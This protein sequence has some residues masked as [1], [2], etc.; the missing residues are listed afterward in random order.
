MDLRNVRTFI[1]LPYICMLPLIF[2]TISYAQTERWVY[3]Y[4]GTGYWD[5]VARDIVYGLDGNIY[6]AGSSRSNFNLDDFTVISLSSSGSERWVYTN[7]WSGS[8]DHAYGVTYGLDG[9]IYV[10]GGGDSSN[11]WRGTVISLTPP[12]SERWI[13][14]GNC[15]ALSG[16]SITYGSD[17]YIYGVAASQG[18]WSLTSS[19]AERWF[20]VDDSLVP[21]GDI[22]YGSD[23]HIYVPGVVYRSDPRWD[24]AVLS[25]TS[26]GIKRWLY[27]YNSI[28]GLSANAISI[29]CG[30]DGNIYAVGYYYTDPITY[31]IMVASIT[32]SGNE[33]WIYGT[34]TNYYTSPY[35]DIVYGSD[36]NLY[37]TVQLEDSVTHLAVISL[38]SSGSERWIYKD[39]TGMAGS[40][41]SIVY[42][43]DDY[44]Y[45]TGIIHRL[46][47]GNDFAIV[48]LTSS[49]SEIWIYTHNGSWGV[50]DQPT[51]MVYGTDGNIYAAGISDVGGAVFEDFAVISVNPVTGIEKHQS[52]YG[53]STNLLIIPNPF[54]SKT[55]IK[56]QTVDDCATTIKICD[57]SGRVVKHFENR[58][59]LNYITWNGHDDYDNTLP[60]GVYFLQFKAGD[61]ST[62]EKLL[63]LR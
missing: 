30:T 7:D 13:Y 62:T 21:S 45:A 20:Y 15:G 51:S 25:L 46:I 59:N 22:V 2:T 39:T 12:G 19:G 35:Y 43:S 57:V 6:A 63:L 52:T 48:G 11:I 14:R 40:G 8:W 47:T 34:G 29:C 49:G 4:N 17:G 54:Y 33:R 5:D 9:N 24:F 18:V 38:T 1:V 60:S 58:I 61:Y 23:G 31:E 32:P 27:T 37:S 41:V 10:A 55:I 3:T 16:G 56:W 53:G 44:I 36:G 42:G 50:D 28:A 26:N